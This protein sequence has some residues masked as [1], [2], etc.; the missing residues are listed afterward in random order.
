MTVSLAPR[1][2]RLV[3]RATK[4]GGVVLVA[5][6]LEAGGGTLTGLTLGAAGTALALTTVF[7]SDTA[8]DQ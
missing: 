4:L 2:Y 8:T 7:V 3:D 6:G 1:T 5:A